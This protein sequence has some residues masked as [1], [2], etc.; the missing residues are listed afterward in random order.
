MLKLKKILKTIIVFIISMI[1]ICF[2]F[3]LYKVINNEIL[4]TE[5]ISETGLYFLYTIGYG[6]LEGDAVI[7]NIL[8][9]IGIVA[10]A[11]MTTFLTI[12]LFWRLD[13]VK[14]NTEYIEIHQEAKTI[15]I[16]LKNIEDNIEQVKEIC[17]TIFK[18]NNNLEGKLEIGDLRIITK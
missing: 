3:S 5:L 6:A 1:I 16:E 12:N 11:L 4:P 15:H 18:E 13:D 17:Y 2:L 8:A 14:L 9:M 7:Q 10:L